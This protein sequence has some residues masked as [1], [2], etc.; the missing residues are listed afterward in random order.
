MTSQQDDYAKKRRDLQDYQKA[1]NKAASDAAKR[2]RD[3]DKRYKEFGAIPM[4]IAHVRNPAG[5]N[6]ALMRL[7]D[8][9]IEDRACKKTNTDLL[10]QVKKE[11][12]A[13]TLNANL[14]SQKRQGY[15]IK[16]VQKRIDANMTAPV[17]IQGCQSLSD[18]RKRFKV[19][20]LGKANTITRKVTFIFS[21]NAVVVNGKPYSFVRKKSK[22]HAYKIIKFKRNKI[23][24]EV[25]VK[26]LTNLLSAAK[27]H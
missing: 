16:N 27:Q 13:I 11:F 10:G 14:W 22:G 4:I 2:I 26:A 12:P 7:V 1:V 15:F 6:K 18:V 5:K 21:P 3:A 25:R 17:A 19:S 20:S 23:T 9:V 24:Y 8:L